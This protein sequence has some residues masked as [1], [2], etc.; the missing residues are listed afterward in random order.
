MPTIEF[1]SVSVAFD[2]TVVLEDINLTLTEQR[3]G[4]IGQNGGGKGSLMGGASLVPV[5]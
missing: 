2:D 5:R 4:I 3:I 1:S